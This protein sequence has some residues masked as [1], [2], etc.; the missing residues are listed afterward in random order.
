M[1]ASFWDFYI[2]LEQPE[3]TS[4]FWL[5]GF[6]ITEYWTVRDWGYATP[7]DGWTSLEELQEEIAIQMS[8][9]EPK[10]SDNSHPTDQ[11]METQR[12]KKT[13]CDERAW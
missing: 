13:F 3:P 11:K 7:V 6:G 12:E 9:T 5:K 10:N 8:Q 1:L 4:N 2:N